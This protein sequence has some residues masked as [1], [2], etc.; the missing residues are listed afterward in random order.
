[1]ASIHARRPFQEKLPTPFILFRFPQH[2]FA[3]RLTLVVSQTLK[4]D[5]LTLLTVDGHSSIVRAVV[6][7]GLCRRVE[8]ATPDLLDCFEGASIMRRAAQRGAYG[9]EMQLDFIRPDKPMENT[10]IESFNGRLLG[11]CLNVHQFIPPTE[12]QAVLAQLDGTTNCGKRT[13]LRESIVGLS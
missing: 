4:C 1:M 5:R 12:A 3:H 11:K 9:H 2:R 6:C 7:Y 10:F 8:R 13:L